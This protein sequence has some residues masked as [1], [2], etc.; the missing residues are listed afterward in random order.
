MTVDISLR[1]PFSLPRLLR[2]QNDDS[3]YQK[4]HWVGDKHDADK[5]Q[6]ESGGQN[7]D[8]KDGTDKRKYRPLS[9]ITLGEVENI[10]LRF[11]RQLIN[12]EAG[13]I[14][15]NSFCH[16]H[17]K[18]NED[19]RPPMLFGRVITC[20][21]SD[22][23]I[24][25]IEELEIHFPHIDEPPDVLHI[26]RDEIEQ[27]SHKQV[28]SYFVRVPVLASDDE[29]AELAE[30]DLMLKANGF[31][32]VFEASYLDL[33][34]MTTQI[35]AE[36]PWLYVIGSRWFASVPES[37]QVEVAGKLK[38]MIGWG[39]QIFN[40]HPEWLGSD[41]VTLNR[42]LG[43]KYAFTPHLLIEPGNVQELSH[44]VAS[45]FDEKYLNLKP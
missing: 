1:R 42:F 33:L 15:K 20:Y 24:D 6:V 27:N 37:L 41:V 10:Y 4:Y 39:K 18:R 21:P 22:G 13:W 11:E 7:R 5:R 43:Y 44:I 17:L 32:P 26:H 30:T 9:D 23:Y 31:Y 2:A 25:N 8:R 36:H 3:R 38:E 40:F 14:G 34:E 35:Q 29:Q 19:G 12:G 45:V 16:V 28:Q